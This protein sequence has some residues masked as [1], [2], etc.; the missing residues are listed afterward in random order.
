LREG[1]IIVGFAGEPIAGIDDL[2]RMLSHLRIGV[3]T[4]MMVLRKAE[5]IYIVMT[6]RESMG[7]L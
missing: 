2:Q 4:P 3:P 6:P 7:A 1:D 5:R